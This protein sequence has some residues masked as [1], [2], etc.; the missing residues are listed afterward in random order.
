MENFRSWIDELS[1]FERNK[2]LKEVDSLFAFEEKEFPD[3]SDTGFKI[4]SG[5]KPACP[6][7][8]FFFKGSVIYYAFRKGYLYFG[9]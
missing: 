7:Q 2:L 3:F 1:K 5:R 6:L 9:L 4:M 8:I